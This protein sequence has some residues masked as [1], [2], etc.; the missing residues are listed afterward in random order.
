MVDEAG[1]DPTRGAAIY[2]PATLRAYDLYVH[3]FSN[4]LIWGCPTRELHDLYRRN[5]SGR[6]LDVGVGTGYFL[7]RCRWPT[8]TP[9]IVLLDL[10]AHALRYTRERIRRYDPVAVRGNVLEP[11]QV[12]EAPFDSIAL[13]YVLHCLPGDLATKSAVFRN[14]GRLLTPGGVLFG[15]T[16]LGQGVRPGW[17]ARVLLALYNRRGIFSNRTDSRS[18]LG[19]ALDG[20][21]ERVEI[22]ERGCVALFEARGYREPLTRDGGH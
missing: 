10:N 5:A 13:L 22:R 8:P 16:V 17:I 4:A 20:H 9:R 12:P 3:G 6:H 2:N 1:L 14:L 11:L 19:E 18:R 15:A 21:F 7:D